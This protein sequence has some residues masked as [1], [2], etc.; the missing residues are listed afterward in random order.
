MILRRLVLFIALLVS[1]SLLA[2]KAQAEPKIFG[3]FWGPSHWETFTVTPYLEDPQ[4]TQN[5]QWSQRQWEPADWSAQYKDGS[6]A[7]IQKFYKS[8]ILHRQYMDDGVP[9][10]EVGP[11]FYHLSGHDKRRVAKFV[12]EHYQITQGHLNGMYTLADW[13]THRPIGLYTV[14]GLQL[15]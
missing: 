4:Y 7:V 5:T 8:G 11:N 10:L 14:S 9:V 6:D 15:Q 13:R 12:D 3:L 1:V 2:G